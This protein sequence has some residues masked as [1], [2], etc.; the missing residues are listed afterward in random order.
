MRFSS[1]VA[2]SAVMAQTSRHVASARR[3]G[4]LVWSVARTARAR[5][6]DAS[7]NA[8]SPPPTRMDSTVLCAVSAGA[9][10][11]AATKEPAPVPKRGACAKAR[12]PADQMLTRWL[13][14][15]PCNC[16]GMVARR[17]NVPRGTM[18]QRAARNGGSAK[19]AM[20]TRRA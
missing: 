12:Q 14:S 4:P 8:Q 20:A 5:S 13:K 15:P 1:T 18:N 7:S 3:R 9:R 2:M 17:S 11:A 10:C 16:S 19:T 6:S